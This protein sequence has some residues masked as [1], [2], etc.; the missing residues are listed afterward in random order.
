MYLTWTTVTLICYRTDPVLDK[1]NPL[2][3]DGWGAFLTSGDARL[4]ELS[5]TSKML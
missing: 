2:R 1:R 3:V 5:A 4:Y